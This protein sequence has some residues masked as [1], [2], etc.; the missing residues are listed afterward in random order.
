MFL[1]LHPGH[2]VGLLACRQGTVNLVDRRNGLLLSGSDC[3]AHKNAE[4]IGEFHVRSSG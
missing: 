1:T 4:T 3:K 2:F